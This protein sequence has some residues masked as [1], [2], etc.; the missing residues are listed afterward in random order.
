LVNRWAVE[1]LLRHGKVDFDFDCKGD[2]LAEI[3]AWFDAQLT[4]DLPVGAS[5][6]KDAA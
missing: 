2:A 5:L 6:R 3:E 4:L 1:Q